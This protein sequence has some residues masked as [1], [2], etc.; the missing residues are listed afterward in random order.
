MVSP[1]NTPNTQAG[2]PEQGAN[3][4]D[5]LNMVPAAGKHAARPSEAEQRQV[6]HEYPQ[7]D[8]AALAQEGITPT[9]EMYRDS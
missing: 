9:P 2:T 7:T 4:N 6:Q 3:P 5:H 1:D 8:E